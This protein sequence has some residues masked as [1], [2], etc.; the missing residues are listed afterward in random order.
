VESKPFG[1][2]EP[3]YAGCCVGP[4]TLAT[5]CVDDNIYYPNSYYS[6]WLALLSNASI[7]L[8]HANHV[9]SV[10]REAPA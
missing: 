2:S 6:T 8:C 10:G 5:Y 3:G 4:C 1:S 7:Y 9:D